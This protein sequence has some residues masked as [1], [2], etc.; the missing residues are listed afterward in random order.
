M[1][2]SSIKLAM[3]KAWGS[4][5]DF[6]SVNCNLKQVRMISQYPLSAMIK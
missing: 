4:F 5:D 6:V 3:V 1:I 2:K